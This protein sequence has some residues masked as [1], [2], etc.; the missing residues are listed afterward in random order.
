MSGTNYDI[1]E[2]VKKNVY[3]KTI[4]DIRKAVEECNGNVSE[5]LGFSLN[6]VCDVTHSVAGTFWYYDVN[7]THCIVA[8]V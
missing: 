5:V 1:W 3:E 6:A 7:D 4:K 2:S 8:K